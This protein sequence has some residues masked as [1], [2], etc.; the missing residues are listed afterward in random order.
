MR[1]EAERLAHAQAEVIIA[2]IDAVLDGLA[3]PAAA[4]AR[5]IEL[6]VA[7]LRTHA[8]GSSS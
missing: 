2:V 1:R 8:A 5:W 7:E 3:L 6:A 4:R